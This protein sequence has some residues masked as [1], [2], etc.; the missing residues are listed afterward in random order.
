MWIMR[1]YLFV[2][3][4]LALSCT[5]QAALNGTTLISDAKI[6][7]IKTRIANRVQPT[8]NAYLSMKIWVDAHQL[9]AIQAPSRWD[10]PDS[11][12]NRNYYVNSITHD[13]QLA[14]KLALAYRITGNE[15]YAYNCRRILMGWARNITYFSTSGPSKLLWSTRFP[16]FIV[17]ADLI[18]H[19]SRFPAAEQQE[20][21]TFVRNKN[22]PMNTMGYA[23]N[24]ANFGLMLV[25]STATYL[26]DQTLFDK[27]TARWKFLIEDQ[28]TS[29]GV[30]RYE[31]TRGRDGLWYTNFALHAQTV[32]GEIIRVNGVDL[33]NYV[34]P[35]GHT[36]KSAYA[37]AARWSLNPCSYPYA[38]C[39]TR[40]IN[41]VGYMEILNPRWPNT[42]AAALLSKYRPLDSRWAVP[43]LTLT[44]G[45]F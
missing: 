29:A 1:K 40:G 31:V 21:K 34:S 4:A 37:N 19:S 3:L 27:G 17:A 35:S 32:S 23:N 30:M 7:A 13:M 2:I 24:W 28:I 45:G 14:Y 18:K 26:Q 25:V 41:Y 22:L 16:G 38:N 15:L 8:Y 9:D 33:F 43:V 5:A 44:H 20:F 11:G 42:N 39:P 36:L 6:A 10:V 12:T